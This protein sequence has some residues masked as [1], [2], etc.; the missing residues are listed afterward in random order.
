[1]KKRLISLSLLVICCNWSSLILAKSSVWKVTKG[2]NSVYIGGTVHILRAQ[3]YPLPAEFNQAYK[4]ADKLVFETDMLKMQ[5]PQ[6]AVTM[7]KALSYADQT[8][9]QSTISN[10][11]YQKLVNY[12]ESIGFPINYLRKA[13]P[14]MVMSTLVV[15]EMQRAGFTSPGVDLHFTNLAQNDHKERLQLETIEEQL[16]FLAGLGKGHEEDFYQKL[17]LDLDN[18]QEQIKAI[19]AY[20]RAGDIAALDKE[21]NQLMKS[22]FPQMYQDLLVKRNKNWMPKLKAFFTTPE[23]EF[24]LVGAAHLAGEDSILAMLKNQGFQVTQL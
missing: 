14:G 4:A 21:M 20:W 24:I 17:L 1:M 19:I 13:K 5:D 7:V 6:L 10:E 16:A 23:V 18:M 9:L 11:T 8:T 2:N 3:D 12:T 22:T 15:M